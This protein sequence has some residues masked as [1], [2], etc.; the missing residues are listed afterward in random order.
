MTGTTPTPTA[1]SPTVLVCYDEGAWYGGSEEERQAQ[2]RGLLAMYVDQLA[3]DL[4]L[5][6]EV[7]TEQVLAQLEKIRQKHRDARARAKH[8]A[9]KSGANLEQAQRQAERQQHHADRRDHT[10]ALIR[11]FRAQARRES[12]GTR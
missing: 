5:P 3:T 9:E 8:Y 7:T 2:L 10:T 1:S 12:A 6:P 11:R 4:S